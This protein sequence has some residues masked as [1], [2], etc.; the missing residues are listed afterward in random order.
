MQLNQVAKLYNY[1]SPIIIL[2]N[3]HADTDTDE[4]DDV[5]SSS[6]EEASNTMHPIHIRS[7]QS[8]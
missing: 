1:T 4:S 3:V 2:L 6:S 8:N 7:Q 5:F